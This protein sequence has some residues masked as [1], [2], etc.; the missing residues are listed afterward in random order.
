MLSLGLVDHH[1]HNYHADKFLSLLRGPLADLGAVI[2]TAW[3]SHPTD[4][5]P[6]WCL[7]NGVERAPSAEAVA[8]TCDAVLVM[9][10]DNIEVHLDLCSRV[11]P[12]GKPCLVDKYLADTRAE[13]EAILHL[14]EQHRVKLFSASSLWF[15]VEL[16]AALTTLDQGQG[17]VTGGF[18]RGMGVWPG[19]GIHTL[20]LIL[21]GMG[22]RVARLIDT[23]D[24]NA[25]LLTLEFTDGRR[26]AVEV[27]HSANQWEALPWSFGFHQGD[28]CVTGTVREYDAFYTNLM[29][30]TVQFFQTGVS[31]ISTEQMLTLCTVLEFASQSRTQ[32]GVWV[33]L[34]GIADTAR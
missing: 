19:Y 18:A 7:T 9:A 15:S 11:F 33:T 26:A 23:G 20:S 5:R 16:E 27:R 22:G 25:A 29:R 30:Q 24:A 17:P 28:Q 8:E 34:P 31:P 32:G 2:T 4:G 13:A 21:R 1:L 6:D 3:E 14:A 10:P 12:A